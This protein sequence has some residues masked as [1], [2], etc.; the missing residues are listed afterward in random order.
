[1]SDSRE[2]PVIEDIENAANIIAAM[3]KHIYELEDRVIELEQ[4]KEIAE[5][6][7]SGGDPYNRP[8]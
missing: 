3:L 7:L 4:F 8:D 1:M 2:P 5:I 6:Q